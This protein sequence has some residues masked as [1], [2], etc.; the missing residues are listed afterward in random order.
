MS[1]QLTGFPSNLSY[2][3]SLMTWG[4]WSLHS[5]LNTMPTHLTFIINLFANKPS[6]NY[7]NLSEVSV[8]CEG[9]E[10]GMCGR[11]KQ[12]MVSEVGEELEYSV[13]EV[14]KAMAEGILKCHMQLSDPVE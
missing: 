1:Q 5:C 7:S 4:W 13:I 10:K 6:P 2:L 14:I 3:L 11:R 9:P 8:S 12:K